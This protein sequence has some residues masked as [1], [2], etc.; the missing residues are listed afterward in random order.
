M[1]RHKDSEKYGAGPCR[2]RL[3]CV[4]IHAQ[5][6]VGAMPDA[7]LIQS[8]ADVGE[9]PCAEQANALALQDPCKSCIDRGELPVGESVKPGLH[10][11]AAGI[12]LEQLDAP[13]V[14]GDLQHVTDG[15][16]VRATLGHC[17]IASET[18]Q[19]LLGRC[20]QGPCPSVSVRRA[21]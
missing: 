18:H 1:E 8:V 21:P 6:L 14:Q 3:A 16:A 4:G 20:G 10:R 17:T 5:D 7:E 19:G 15:P 2:S 12:V 9:P 13:V 11:A